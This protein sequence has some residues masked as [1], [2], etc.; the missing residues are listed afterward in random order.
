MYE[1]RRII[2]RDESNKPFTVWGI[3]NI[4]EEFIFNADGT[5]IFE[6]ALDAQDFCDKI[7]VCSDGGIITNFI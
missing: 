2:Q 1:T 6:T 3:V 5:I 4:Y 7:N